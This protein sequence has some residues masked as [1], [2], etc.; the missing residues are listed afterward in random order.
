MSNDVSN[1]TLS[2]I[3]FAPTAAFAMPLSLRLFC[4]LTV[5]RMSSHYRSVNVVLRISLVTSTSVTT[6]PML[7]TENFLTLEW[8]QGAK[9]PESL[10]TTGFPSVALASAVRL[11][12]VTRSTQTPTI[13]LIFFTFIVILEPTK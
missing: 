2:V 6:A 12:R 7:S 1:A 4:V 3:T 9:S 10:L 5:S 13:P 8:L 11:Y